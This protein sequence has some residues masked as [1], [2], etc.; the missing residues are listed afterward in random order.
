ME[1]VAEMGSSTVMH[2][3]S[4]IKTGLDIKEFMRGIHRQHG[5]LGRQILFFFKILKLI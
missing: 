1:L 4:F 3:P 5:D 2:V